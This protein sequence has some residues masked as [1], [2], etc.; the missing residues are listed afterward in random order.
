MRLPW[1]SRMRRLD[2]L[3]VASHLR[4]ED[5][6]LAAAGSWHPIVPP[7]LEMIDLTLSAAAFCWA[8][9]LM[10]TLGEPVARTAN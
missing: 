5:A 6:G 10:E 4:P 1:S 8:N 7:D 2:V 9:R 3:I